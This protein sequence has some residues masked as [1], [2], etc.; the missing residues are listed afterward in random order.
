MPRR[1]ECTASKEK[2][3]ERRKISD[4]Y[5]HENM[6]L[7]QKLVTPKL[8]FSPRGDKSNVVHELCGASNIL[9]MSKT[10]TIGLQDAV[11]GAFPFSD[12]SN[13]NISI[14]DYVK[15]VGIT[16]KNAVN[17]KLPC[18]SSIFFDSNQRETK[19]NHAQVGVNE[20]FSRLQTF[21]RTGESLD[22]GW[23]KQ[24]YSLIVWKLASM[25]RAF[26]S[27]FGGSCLS[28][29]KVFLQLLNRYDIEYVRGKRSVLTRIKE[30]DELASI[31]LVLCVFEITSEETTVRMTDGWNFVDVIL[32]EV[33][34]TFVRGGKIFVG[35]KLRLYGCEIIHREGKEIALKAGVNNTR[36]AEWYAK[37]GAQKCKPPFFGLKSIR[38]GGGV[39]PRILVVVQR[40]FPV[41]VMETDSKGRKVWKSLEL[42]A[43]AQEEA[44]RKHEECWEEFLARRVCCDD[45]DENVNLSEQIADLRTEFLCK[46][47]MRESAACP[48]FR[49]KVTCL[50]QLASESPV[51]AYI[52]CWRPQPT[53][54]ESI[55]EGKCL[56]I[57][58]LQCG[59]VIKN[60]RICLSFL[61]GTQIS[62]FYD[63]RAA[64][65]FSERK[66]L[67]IDNLDHVSNR[68]EFDVIGIVAA[69]GRKY[70]PSGQGELKNDSHHQLLALTSIK[71][72]IAAEE[73]TDVQEKMGSQ[74]IKDFLIV[75]INLHSVAE[76]R[77]RDLIREPIVIGVKD[78][79]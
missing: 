52:T 47:E 64:N 51:Q 44:N 42:Y 20:M 17:V 22:E 14:Q 28:A 41:L 34:V 69:I 8:L 63:S 61:P 40:V 75:R 57:C 29:D 26:P 74:S 7:D 79:R 13:G 76:F 68:D 35:Q 49:F 18:E 66:F 39:V 56:S 45:S 9:Q 48:V 36:R 78:L 67:S 59:K 4:A 31:H 58:N 46:T 12:E 15:I 43:R 6:P 24:H 27:I 53:I 2:T 62:D 37:L 19:N 50:Q 11:H 10:N 60:D 70:V 30:R 71:R 77:Q 32:D 33:L 55:Q 3:V 54:V 16:A 23:A 38:P 65:L 73:Q 72:D 1:T 25:E 21:N 5:L